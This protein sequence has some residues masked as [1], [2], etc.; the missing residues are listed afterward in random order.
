MLAGPTA[1]SIVA[2]GGT[3]GPGS[4]ASASQ[5]PQGGTTDV[6]K[7]PATRSLLHKGSSGSAVLAVQR[8]LNHFLPHANVPTD[9]YYGWKTRQAVRTFQAQRHLPVTGKIDAD[10]WTA[11]FPTDQVV[12]PG[13]DTSSSS[14]SDEGSGSDSSGAEQ[15]QGAGESIGTGKS[16]S[17]KRSHS[18]HKKAHRSHSAHHA[19]QGGH[20]HAVV[21]HAGAPKGGMVLDGGIALPLPKQYLGSGSIDNGVDYSAPGGTPLFAMG[22]GVVIQ[23]GIG[24]FGPN[25]IVIKITSGPL[26]GKIVYYG[27]NGPNTVRVGDHVR[28]GQQISIVGY[29]IVGHSTGPHLEVGFW[30]LSGN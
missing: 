22:D 25:A 2:A 23:V 21:F 18:S 11:L 10:T 5:D 4:A 15:S 8:E 6:G 30:P 28:A 16:S 13:S 14:S 7:A 24:G 26:A 19:K 27:H 17:H 9:G 3:S 20:K 1:P 12:M 29:G